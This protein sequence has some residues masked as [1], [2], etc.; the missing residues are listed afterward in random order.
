M[1]Q[2]TRDFRGRRDVTIIQGYIF[3][4][5][6]KC[7]EKIILW[8]FEVVVNYNAPGA[9]R[10]ALDGWHFPALR[11]QEILAQKPPDWNADLAIAQHCRFMNVIVLMANASHWRK[12]V[13]RNLMEPASGLSGLRYIF[14]TIL[15]V[16]KKVGPYFWVRYFLEQVSSMGN[17]KERKYLLEIQSVQGYWHNID[18]L[19]HRRNKCCRCRTFF[20]AFCWVPACS[21]R[22]AHRRRY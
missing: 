20:V 17:M 11:I 2:L 14:T 15:R 22:M 18:V 9:T 16:E 19:E 7:L 6:W 4:K 5:L 1:R 10:I 21:S 8:D 13:I 12:L 3:F